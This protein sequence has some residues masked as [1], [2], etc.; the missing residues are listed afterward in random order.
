MP[1]EDGKIHYRNY[2]KSPQLQRL[3][4]RLSDG[5]EYS[6]RE[7]SLSTEIYS[8][9]TAIC[10]LRRNGY[11]VS[12]RKADNIHYYRLAGKRTVIRIICQFCKTT[13]G[14]KEGHGVSG[15]SHG[16]CP[17]CYPGA[18]ERATQTRHA[19]TAQL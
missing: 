9:S 11:P 5:K 8:V 13:Q 17:K 14:E 6:T 2:A 1:R 3:W 7:L 16:I 19:L 18:M 10:E 4:Q 15:D 12:H